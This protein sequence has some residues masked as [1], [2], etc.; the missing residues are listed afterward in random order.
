MG[1]NRDEACFCPCL[2]RV[3]RVLGAYAVNKSIEQEQKDIE[4]SKEFCWDGQ[5]P[6]IMTSGLK[7]I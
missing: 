3:I 5:L 6:M 4:I 1:E 7:P 2:I